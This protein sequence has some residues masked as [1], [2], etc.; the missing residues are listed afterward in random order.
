MHRPI[1]PSQGNLENI[2]NNMGS[3]PRP[4]PFNAGKV[5]ELRGVALNN[6]LLEIASVLERGA[7]VDT[8]SF[9]SVMRPSEFRRSPFPILFTVLEMTEAV[10]VEMHK[11]P[12]LLLREIMDYSDM[13]L[14]GKTKRFEGK[15]KMHF[16]K[17]S[18]EV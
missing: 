16:L 9:L 2:A 8:L 3:V 10:F 13:H 17:F 1:L 6:M 18:G 11:L 4:F 12:V 5:K 15:Y 14:C 7:G